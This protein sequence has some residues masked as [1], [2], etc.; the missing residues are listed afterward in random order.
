MP[1][2]F[3]E[4]KQLFVRHIVESTAHLPNFLADNEL[5]WAATGTPVVFY[6]HQG[7][8]LGWFDLPEQRPDLPF[9]YF[10]EG[11]AMP[12]PRERFFWDVILDDLK[13]LASCGGS[14]R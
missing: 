5:S 12:A 2:G 7:Y 4:V 8:A 1:I 3:G 14:R 6:D 13:F 9:W 10:T 11:D